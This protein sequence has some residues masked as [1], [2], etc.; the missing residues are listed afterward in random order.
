[1]ENLGYVLLA[2]AIIYLFLKMFRS[3]DKR[4]K[5]LEDRNNGGD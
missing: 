5:E 3:M 4:I 2:A 1:M